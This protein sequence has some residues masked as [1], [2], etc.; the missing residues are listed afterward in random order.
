MYSDPQ[1]VVYFNSGKELEELG[2]YAEAISSFDQAL[3]IQPDN[4]KCIIG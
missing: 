4:Y 1:A 2:R 3:K